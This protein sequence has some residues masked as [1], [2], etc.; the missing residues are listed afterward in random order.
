[1]SNGRPTLK[2]DLC[3]QQRLISAW[4]STQS[5]QS[6]LSACPKLPKATHKAHAKTPIRLDSHSVN[7]FRKKKPLLTCKVSIIK[8]KLFNSFPNGLFES[9]IDTEKMTESLQTS[10]HPNYRECLSIPL[11]RFCTRAATSLKELP[12]DK[13]NKVTCAPSEDSDQPGHLPSLI[14]VCAVRSVGSRGPKV[15]SCGQRRL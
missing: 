1:M 5:D 9:Q 7:N 4:A 13:T 3:V 11:G 10:Y 6:S 2:N 12:H 8:H 15:S 14:R